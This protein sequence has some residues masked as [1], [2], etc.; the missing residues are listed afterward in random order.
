[1]RVMYL[2]H[3]YASSEG[4]DESA[5]LSNLARAYAARTYI[6]WRLLTT[7]I[8][9]KMLCALTLYL[10]ETPFSTFAN[11]ADSDQTALV[12]AA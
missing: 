11:R 4:T 6:L 5:L 1:M 10:I 8:K 12:R 9:I 3:A 2:S 7:R